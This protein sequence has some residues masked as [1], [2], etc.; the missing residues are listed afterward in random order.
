MAPAEP[1]PAPVQPAAPAEP[2]PVERPRPRAPRHEAP[3]PTPAPAPAPT[4]GTLTID[5][6]VPGASV[7]IDCRYLGKTP[8][9]Q[10]DVEPGSHTLNVSAGGYDPWSSTID[11]KPGPQDV[12]V[13]FKQVKLDEKIAVVHKHRFGSCQGMLIATPE[14]I[15]YDTTDRN[16]AFAVPFSRLE[17]FE[18]DYLKNNLEIKVRGGRTYN[19]TEQKGG[20]DTLFVFHRDVQKAIALM[21]KLGELK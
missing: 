18:V 8:I 3:A 1:A 11:V 13:K 9:T 21:K 4:T 14:G 2:K 5:S 7:F 19:F 15:R 12:T 6:D 10:P 17:T 20:P 16:D